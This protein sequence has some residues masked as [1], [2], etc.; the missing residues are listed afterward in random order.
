MVFQE[1]CPSGKEK[2]QRPQA[3]GWG[4]VSFAL[5]RLWMLHSQ[6]IIQHKAPSSKFP[7][8]SPQLGGLRGLQGLQK[9]ARWL[10]WHKLVKLK[11]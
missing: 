1:A 3:R 8:L 6:D 2:K 5:L 9:G 4:E 7:A 11:L 10:C